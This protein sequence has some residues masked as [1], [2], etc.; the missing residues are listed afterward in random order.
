MVAERVGVGISGVDL[1]QNIF[2]FLHAQMQQLSFGSKAQE[3]ERES[4]LWQEE[5]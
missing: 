2:R 5:N 3:H 1:F 4:R